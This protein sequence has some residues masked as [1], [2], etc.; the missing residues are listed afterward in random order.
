MGTHDASVLSDAEMCD[1][2]MLNVVLQTHSVIVVCLWVLGWARGDE[3]EGKG[4]G[5][6]VVM[7]G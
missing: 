7:C 3:R 2:E 1:A 6:G 4:E 5:G